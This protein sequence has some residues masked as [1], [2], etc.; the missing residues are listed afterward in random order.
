MLWKVEF[1]KKRSCLAFFVD[2]TW[3]IRFS[4]RTWG[5]RFSM[6]FMARWNL[7]LWYGKKNLKSNYIYFLETFSNRIFKFFR[8]KP[9]LKISLVLDVW[10]QQFHPDLDNVVVPMVIFSRV[11][12]SNSTWRKSN[13]RRATSKFC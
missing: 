2:Y 13:P 5:P 11:K 6:T 10:L 12:N 1:L 7:W 4:N 3:S 8:L 9:L